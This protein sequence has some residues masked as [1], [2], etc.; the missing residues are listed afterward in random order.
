MTLSP[1]GGLEKLA[2]VLGAALFLAGFSTTE[3][4]AGPMV[5][6]GVLFAEP[7]D[8]PAGES[9]EGK[10]GGFG[11]GGAWVIGGFNASPESVHKIEK[12]SLAIIGLAASGGSCQVGAAGSIVGLERPLAD[13]G[14]FAGPGVT[15]YLSFIVRPEGTLNAGPLN[16]FFG[17]SLRSKNSELFIGKPGNEAVNKW[18]MEERGGAGQVASDAPV[19]LD[20]TTLLVVK[21][22]HKPD[23]DRATLYVN[24]KPGDP[25]PKTGTIKDNANIGVTDTLVIYSTGA[26]SLDEIRGGDSFQSV[27]PGDG[28]KPGR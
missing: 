16:G 10:A 13:P 14:A 20:H 5:G 4:T 17:L 2:I 19:V 24:P 26:F 27:T 8:Y 28:E 15:A 7:F 22:E 9:L 1:T 18:V 11:L 25:E 6:R 21:L 23:G 12:G 3:T